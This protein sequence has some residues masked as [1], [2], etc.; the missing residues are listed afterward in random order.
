MIRTVVIPCKN[1]LSLSIPN[2]YIG[3]RVEIIAFALD[4][5]AES[6]VV[7]LQSPKRFSAVKLQTKDFTF[8]RDEANERQ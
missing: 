8:D 5:P 3:R 7:K 2:D 6:E 1:S 4:E